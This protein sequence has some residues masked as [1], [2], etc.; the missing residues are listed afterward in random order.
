MQ[1]I[2]IFASYHECTGWYINQ[3]IAS[4]IRVALGVVLGVSGAMIVLGIYGRPQKKVPVP[5][6]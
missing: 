5:S 3:L 6:M 4:V 1:H 2:N